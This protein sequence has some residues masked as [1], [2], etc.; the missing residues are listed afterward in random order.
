MNIFEGFGFF[1]LGIVF[2]VLM[3]MVFFSVLMTQIKGN[4]NTNIEKFTGMM[5]KLKGEK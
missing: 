2:N 3:L 4:I 1:I 5:L